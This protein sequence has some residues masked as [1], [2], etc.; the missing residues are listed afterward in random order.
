MGKL[1]HLIPC[2]EQEGK[3][4]RGGEQGSPAPAAG[5]SAPPHPNTNCSCTRDR[6][7]LDPVGGCSSP[8]FSVA[9]NSVSQTQPTQVSSGSLRLAPVR[10]RCRAP[11]RAAGGAA[12]T[13]GC[14]QPRAQPG[15]SRRTRHGGLHHMAKPGYPV[16][17]TPSCRHPQSHR[18]ALAVA[19]LLCL[20]H[21]RIR[22]A[23]FRYS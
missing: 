12:G 3:A 13:P 6:A 18:A 16:S 8:S 1:D 23:S 11:C 4:G 7:Q 20:R 2:W 15:C 10:W 17:P 21:F 22:Y 5:G 19:A 14:L 9:E